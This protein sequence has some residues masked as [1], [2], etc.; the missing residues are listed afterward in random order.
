M[1]YTLVFLLVI[2]TTKLFSQEYKEGILL[3]MSF[4]INTEKPVPNKEEKF[5]NISKLTK[6]ANKYEIYGT[7]KHGNL[8]MILTKRNPLDSKDFEYTDQHGSIY[9]IKDI[10]DTPAKAMDILSLERVKGLPENH[11]VLLRVLIR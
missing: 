6:K 5:A 7:K 1:K 3:V 2:L 10:L 11:F 8:K 9:L 4:D